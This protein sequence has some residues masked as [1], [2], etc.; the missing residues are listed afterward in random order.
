MEANSERCPLPVLTEVRRLGAGWPVLI[1]RVEAYMQQVGSEG[2]PLVEFEEACLGEVFFHDRHAIVRA[3]KGK[4]VIFPVR[5]GVAWRV[6]P[7]MPENR[8]FER[9]DE[10]A[11]EQ[12]LRV[13]A[14]HMRGLTR[15]VRARGGV[16]D[17][18]GRRREAEATGQIVTL[19]MRHVGKGLD[20]DE[21]RTALEDTFTAEAV[22]TLTRRQPILKVGSSLVSLPKRPKRAP[23]I[24]NGLLPHDKIVAL[25]KK[26]RP[27]GITKTLLHKAYQ[28]RI[29][30]AEFDVLLADLT[31]AGFI[32]TATM[33]VSHKGRPAL[34]CVHPEF[35]MP[36]VVN[37]RA[38]IH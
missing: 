35:S 21:I 15:I 36:N 13:L 6:F 32:D 22:E 8:R 7:Q 38:M 29:P 28:P 12:C 1:R 2:V 27:K 31:G 26:A 17:R 3:L 18:E 9:D 14:P 20:L 16:A 5:D 19:V 10:T 25:V 37:G 11:V 33:K 23:R 4:R 24:A 30:M 34:V